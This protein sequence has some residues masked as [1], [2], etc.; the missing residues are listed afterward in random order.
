MIY[1]FT[2]NYLKKLGCAIGNKLCKYLY[3]KVW[4]ELYTFMSSSTLKNFYC[5]IIIYIYIYFFTLEWKRNTI[6]RFH[7][8]IKFWTTRNK[9]WFYIFKIQHRVVRFKDLQKQ[10]EEQ[11]ANGNISETNR[12]EEFFLS[13][14]YTVEIID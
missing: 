13:Y 7:H 1:I 12:W 8:K 5:W 14:L 6:I 10:A 4:K 11:L 2:Y 9:I 3:G